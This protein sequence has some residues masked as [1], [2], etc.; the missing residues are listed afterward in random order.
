MN[1]LDYFKTH[2]KYEK[3]PKI[4]EP[5]THKFTEY[6]CRAKEIRV[7][8]DEGV[9]VQLLT[10]SRQWPQ[11]Q[12]QKSKDGDE[13]GDVPENAKLREYKLFWI[14]Y[15]HTMILCELCTTPYSLSRTKILQG[16]GLS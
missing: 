1:A 12:R 9:L 8:L 7:V 6:L 15:S 10:G 5:I 3:N 14:V 13:G 16:P 4:K 2:L 11:S